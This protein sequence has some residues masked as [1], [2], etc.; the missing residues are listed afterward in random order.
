M[1]AAHFDW[2]GPETVDELAVALADNGPG[3]S[4]LEVHKVAGKVFLHVIHVSADPAR[5][6]GPVVL[7]HSFPCP[8]VCP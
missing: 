2:F 3:G 1:R 5:V 7:N 8:P 4:R 6:A